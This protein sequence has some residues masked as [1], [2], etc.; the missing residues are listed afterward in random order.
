MVLVEDASIQKTW[1]KLMA[2]QFWQLVPVTRCLLVRHLLNKLQTNLFLPDAPHA[3]QQK[4]LATMY[5][6]IAFSFEMVF[7]LCENGSP[8]CESNAGVWLD[9]SRCIRYG[10]V[11]GV[12]I[13][14]YRILI[15]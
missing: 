1:A 7:Q 2:I 12:V 4:V 13:D 14:L 9:W 8:A 10:P 3:I 6:V 5:F 15:D 11:A